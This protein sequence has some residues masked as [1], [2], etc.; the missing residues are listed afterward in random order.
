MVKWITHLT[1]YLFVSNCRTGTRRAKIRNGL[2]CHQVLVCWQTKTDQ[3]IIKKQRDRGCYSRESTEWCGTSLWAQKSALEGWG[4]HKGLPREACPKHVKQALD[5]RV[6][7]PHGSQ[8]P[9]CTTSDISR[10][11]WRVTTGLL[12]ARFPHAFPLNY[13]ALSSS[14]SEEEQTLCP[15]PALVKCPDFYRGG[16]WL[17]VFMISEMEYTERQSPIQTHPPFFSYFSPPSLFN[18][19]LGLWGQFRG[20][21]K[22]SHRYCFA[23]FTQAN[24]IICSSLKSFSPSSLHADPC[25]NPPNTH[26]VWA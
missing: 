11:S 25:R 18:L 19:M 13:K 21:Q 24:P 12:L 2:C 23:G 26:E 7:I 22:Q 6:E 4:L 9:D 5:L 14:G 20:R 16:N 3:Q 8:T 10:E 15:V 1:G 17:S